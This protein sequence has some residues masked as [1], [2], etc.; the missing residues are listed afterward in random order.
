MGIAERGETPCGLSGALRREAGQWKACIY[1]LPHPKEL[2][3]VAGIMSSFSWRDTNRY[4]VTLD[5][6]PTA[7]R[8][9]MST[10]AE[11]ANICMEVTYRSRGEH[12]LWSPRDSETAMSPQQPTKS[13]PQGSSCRACCEALPGLLPLA[14][15]SP[16]PLSFPLRDSPQE[17]C[18]ILYLMS[19]LSSLGFSE[20]QE[21]SSFWTLRIFRSTPPPP[22]TSVEVIF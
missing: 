4:L 9:N 13:L 5:R 14:I 19:S 2:W 1:F 10:S 16:S 3:V 7:D 17:S 20:Y 21:P 22:A 18:S 6:A 12:L 15:T 11:W 8:R